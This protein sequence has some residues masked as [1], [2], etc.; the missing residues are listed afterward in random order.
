MATTAIAERL[1]N[2]ELARLQEINYAPV[3]GT[4]ACPAAT[5][6]WMNDE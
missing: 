2:G 6:P 4:S 3:S 1:L 5:H